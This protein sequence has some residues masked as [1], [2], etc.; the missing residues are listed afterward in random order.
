[1]SGSC[2]CNYRVWAIIVVGLCAAALVLSGCTGKSESGE[3]APEE[4]AEKAP[5][6]SGAPHVEPV[7]LTDKSF[8]EMTGKGVVLVA[9]A[10]Q[11]AQE[12]LAAA[13]RSIQS[14]GGDVLGVVLNKRTFPIPRFIYRRV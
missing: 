1:M 10:Q 8:D 3:K 14:G 7:T 9:C 11:T 6:E 13:T 2:N 4:S 12:S 5:E